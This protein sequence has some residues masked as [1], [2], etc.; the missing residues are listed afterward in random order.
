MNQPSQKKSKKVSCIWAYL[1][2]ISL[3]LNTLFVFGYQSVKQDSDTIFDVIISK[4]VTTILLLNLDGMHEWNRY[5]VHVEQSQ[6]ADPFMHEADHLLETQQLLAAPIFM[7]EKFLE[8]AKEQAHHHYEHHLNNIT[9]LANFWEQ[10]P[11]TKRAEF[12]RHQ[13]RDNKPVERESFA[14]FVYQMRDDAIERVNNLQQEYEIA[15][16]VE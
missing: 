3:L 10:L 11:P 2:V 12:L 13:G 14:N 9:S 8:Y 6:M 7:R 15:H 16:P 4:P 1:F 5:K